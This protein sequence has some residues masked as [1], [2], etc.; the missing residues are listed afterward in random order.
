MSDQDQDQIAHG[1]VRDL[2]G[3]EM[4]HDDDAAADDEQK[5]RDLAQ[6]LDDDDDDQTAVISLAIESSGP[7]R[8]WSFGG[9]DADPDHG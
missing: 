2:N 4:A 8:L 9:W 6:V 3:A 7:E 5:R 1:G